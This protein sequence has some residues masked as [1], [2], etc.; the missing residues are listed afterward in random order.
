MVSAFFRYFQNRQNWL[1]EGVIKPITLKSGFT[2]I[3]TAFFI[4]EDKKHISRNRVLDN[5]FRLNITEPRHTLGKK[6]EQ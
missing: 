4:K 1:I 2:K 3:T 5:I 6:I